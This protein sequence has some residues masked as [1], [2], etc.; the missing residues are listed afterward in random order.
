MTGRKRTTFKLNL[1][2]LRDQMANLS[3]RK[4]SLDIEQLSKLEA[5]L[6]AYK[7]LQSEFETETYNLIDQLDETA[8]DYNP[9]LN[10][11]M[12]ELRD[13]SDIAFQNEG[14]IKAFHKKLSMD[15]QRQS[16]VPSN[17]DL[18]STFRAPTTQPKLE[19]IVV[20][21]F[22][23]NILN[24]R[25][26]KGLFENLVHNNEDLSNVQKLY[27]LKQALV[28]DAKDFVR[29]F[30]LDD[31]AYSEAWAH[32]L[33]RFDNK[34]A[35]VK[36]L[37]R[38]LYN[39]EPIKAENQIT[40]LLDKAEII[41]RGLRASDEVIDQTF[42]K[43]VTY[44]VSSK[45]DPRTYKDWENS[46]TTTDSYPQFGE[47]QKFLRIRSFNVLDRVVENNSTLKINKNSKQS[48][49]ASS[50]SEKKSLVTSIKKLKCIVC[51][52]PHFLNQCN[53]F[54]SKTVGERFELVKKHKLCVKCFS[55]FH[56]VADCK[57]YNCRTC[58]GN[59]HLLLHRET[60]SQPTTNISQ[61]NKADSPTASAEANN[62]ITKS[63]LSA[64]STKHKVVFL[65]T[66]VVK[67]KSASGTRLA[68]ILLD[69]GSETTL[70]C[71]NLCNI[72][73]LP[74]TKNENPTVLVGINNDPSTLNS[75]TKFVLQSRYCNFS[76]AIEAEVI[77]KIPYSVTRSNFV[78][79]FDKFPKFKFAESNDLPYCNVDI[80][81]GS[82]YVEWILEDQRQF[83]ED[84][85]L[86]N[87]KFGYVISGAQKLSFLATKTYC[88]LSKVD[89]DS[90][91]KRFF[92][93]E[94]FSECSSSKTSETIFEHK[95]IEDH[96]ESTYERLDDGKFQLRLPTRSNIVN[97]NGSFPKAKAMLL[98][99]ECKR[100][101]I[102][103]A[104]YCDFMLKYKELGHM[105]E[106]SNPEIVPNSYYIPH[107]IVSKLSSSTTKYRVVFNA[108][109]NDNSGTSLNDCLLTGPTLQPELFDTIIKF[110]SHRVA[111]CADIEMMYRQIWIHP[112]D[113]KYQRIVWRSNI[114]EPI[115]HFELNT[116]TYG[117]AP[118][119][120]LATKCLQIIA[121]SLQN[122]N[123]KAANAINSNFYMDDLMTGADTVEET[124]QLQRVVHSALLSAGLPLR[125][126][127]SNSTDFLSCIDSSLIETLNSRL[128]GSESF[129]FVLGLVWSPQSDT[130][131]VSINLK[132]LPT[133]ITKRIFLSDIS[134]IFDVLGML[135][136]V[137][138]RAKILMQNLWREGLGWND[139]VSSEL[140]REFLL[141]RNQL[142]SLSNYRIPRFYTSLNN[143]KSRQLIG[144][145]D[146]S[147]KAYCAVIFIRVTDHS[148]R[149]TS[150]FVCAK[151]RVA[152]IKTIT[153][154]RLELQS[155]VLLAQLLTRIA[156]NLN[157]D[158]SNIFAFSDSQIVLSWLN[159][160][161]NQLKQFISNRISKILN[162]TPMDRWFYVETK[163]NPADLATR[164]LNVDKFVSNSLWLNGPHW[165][166]SEFENHINVKVKLDKEVPETRNVKT[167]SLV[168]IVDYS[169]LTRF[170]SYN[171]LINVVA[172]LL[173]FLNNARK[174]QRNH[175]SIELAIDERNSSLNCI[176]KMSQHCFFSKEIKN[177][178]NKVNVKK[179]SS[180]K[181][182][183]P[184]LDDNGIIR[185][186]GRLKNAQYSFD[187]RHPIIMSAKCKFVKLL[188]N[189]I[190]E[191]YFHCSRSVIYT[192]LEHRYWFVG[193][194]NNVIKYVIRNCVFCTRLRAHTCTQLMG[195]LPAARVT[196][197][198]PFTHCGIDFCGPF[199]VRCLG[200]RSIKY[201]KSYAAFFICFSTRAVH[202]ELVS[203]LS[204]DKFLQSLRR[205]IARR[206]LPSHCYSD[207][208]KNFVGASNKL[209]QERNK[210]VNFA[211][212]EG[213]KWHFIT[214]R[215]P[216]QGGLWEAAIKSGKSLLA[217][218]TRNSILTYEEL[219]TVLCQ[220][221]SILNSR[222][223]CYRKKS[224]ESFGV[225]TPGHFLIG[226]HMLALPI[227]QEDSHLDLEIKFKNLQSIIRSFWHEWRKTYLNT[228]QSRNKWIN[229]QPNLAVNDIIILKE[230]N[231]PILCWPL[232]RIIDVVSDNDGQIR[233]VIVRTSTGI[234]TRSINRIVLL[235]SSEET[236]LL[237]RGE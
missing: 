164:G 214:P 99:S 139:P 72:A 154:P 48:V 211:S 221:E 54:I 47:L 25:N 189:H 206:G 192:H 126:Y 120:Y 223:I 153:I 210:I 90:Q 181:F 225:L 224:N 222:P 173:R 144:F 201:N 168:S 1:S 2:R 26:F 220:V 235:P 228:L 28:G 183:D 179:E 88:G 119:S 34:R 21:S 29:D 22:D 117:T 7:S 42:S 63:S 16:I 61:S 27:Y 178:E 14:M 190:H 71:R 83:Y 43:F 75:L 136:P 182:L 169:I 198:R 3:Q 200:H 203:D 195:Q 53:R 37:F 49:S 145:C 17:I 122:T 84:I 112:N 232:G 78:D 69:P 111:F 106:L 176:I 45:L 20:P 207:N 39:L 127:Q 110:R 108:S 95:M 46:I 170:S 135:S 219:E 151:T 103:R 66:A 227:D 116:V 40:S 82:E 197:S 114:S 32:L 105:S 196:P 129:I 31:R 152:P 44:I 161:V 158:S 167:K 132:P 18:N 57:R 33:S 205:F 231:V 12:K 229:R 149:V 204:S 30:K 50:S 10:S 163:S 79:I 109:A 148:N 137:T 140:E 115:G 233:N 184:F 237:S 4:T 23:G 177:L 15:D 172:Y 185:V 212:T 216:H 159:Y 36:T 230:D 6:S 97:L 133:P 141:Y 101:D 124:I 186:G 19:R 73:K 160:N 217:K 193:G 113:R 236:D 166:T 162:L 150:S 218:A 52:E 51:E 60:S 128:L 55:P 81:L 199:T 107:H 58:N 123:P 134:R 38:D 138:I 9:K 24:F 41:I 56:V 76:I 70:I 93:F 209:Y 59:H 226:D 208:G 86:R 125:K 147:P 8:E 64:A 130:F 77:S 62:V 156:N 121:R 234:Y 174:H 118:A 98:K 191:K 74:L 142:E 67:L 87:T 92:E 187:K 80:V 11:Y 155:A 146:A 91:L 171:K 104:A 68:R 194:I 143:V 13:F 96:F 165:L 157:I 180:L 215:T 175:N 102:V 85:C 100:S 35:V 94:D 213:I 202:I 5:I 89:V 65:S 188:V 131:N